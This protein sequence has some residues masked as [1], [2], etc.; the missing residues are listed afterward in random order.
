MTP[1]EGGGGGFVS[2]AMK[3]EKGGRSFITLMR[4]QTRSHG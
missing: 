2:V 3:K 1:G 4:K